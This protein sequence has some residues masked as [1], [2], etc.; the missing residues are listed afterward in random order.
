MRVLAFIP[1]RGGSKG[2]PKK[3]LALLDGKPLIY[4]S[5]EAARSS[6]YVTDIFISSDDFEIIQYCKSLGIEVEYRRPD[7]LA[8]D[9]TPTIDTVI[10]GLDWLRANSSSLPE[11]VLLLQPTS[12]LRTSEDIDDAIETF[13]SSKAKSLI[14]V[15]KQTEHPYRCLES[16]GEN[17]SFLKRPAEKMSGRQDYPEKFFLINGAIYLTS[18]EFL[19]SKKTFIV[20]GETKL[21]C[22]SQRNGLDIDEP[23]HL[24]WAEFYMKNVP[25]AGMEK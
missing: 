13:R 23:L 9:I 14:S 17:W 4:Y 6:Q 20:E 11:V 2:I 25:T 22:M 10:H 18:T 7:E 12:P 8:E 24:K 21:F 3:N 19:M 16:I 5:I 1:A 15:H